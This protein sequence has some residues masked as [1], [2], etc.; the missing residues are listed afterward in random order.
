M[1]EKAPSAKGQAALPLVLHAATLAV[2]HFEANHLLQILSTTSP[3]LRAKIAVGRLTAL[4]SAPEDVALSLVLEAGRKQARQ[5]QAL[6]CLLRAAAAQQ[7]LQQWRL[8]HSRLEFVQ[9]C[10][11]SSCILL[12][13]AYT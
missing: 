5:P 1:P 13:P 6:G 7:L 12:Y 8:L 10:L 2:L 4:W 3:T 9:E 11:L